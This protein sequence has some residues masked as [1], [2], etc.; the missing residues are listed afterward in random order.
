ML[1]YDEIA[2]FLEEAQR[3]RYQKL[4]EAIQLEVPQKNK[5]TALPGANMFAVN[6]TRATEDMP[7]SQGLPF[8]MN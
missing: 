6:K 8:T 4:K 2:E 1:G 7:A 3:S 5:V